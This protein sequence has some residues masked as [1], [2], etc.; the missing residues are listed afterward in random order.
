MLRRA[1][2]FNDFH[3][4]LLGFINPFYIG[5][6]D[7]DILLYKYLC[8]AFADSHLVADTANAHA[9]HGEAPDR[10]EGQGGN[11]PRQKRGKPVAIHDACVAYPGGLQLIY[12]IRIFYPYRDEIM[13]ELI[14]A[15]Q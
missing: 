11:H 5:K 2:E 15:S 4:F 6:P 3:E 8:L 13:C 14:I 10:N 12:Q 7:S 1:Q 9:S